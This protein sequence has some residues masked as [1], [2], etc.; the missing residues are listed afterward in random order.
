M[1]QIILERLPPTDSIVLLRNFSAH[2]DAENDGGDASFVR[3]NE[4]SK[5]LCKSI[6]NKLCS[7]VYLVLEHLGL[8]MN[9][10]FCVCVIR[11]V[12]I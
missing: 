10:H 7:E 3:N 1:H 9:H 8:K 12:E 11:L 6:T 4:I 2:T 5:L